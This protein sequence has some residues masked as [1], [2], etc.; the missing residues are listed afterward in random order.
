MDQGTAAVE[1]SDFFHT[2]SVQTF[3]TISVDI[4]EFYNPSQRRD[5][6][7]KW[8]SGGGGA[9]GPSAPRK[10]GAAKEDTTVAPKYNP[11]E[12]GARIRKMIEDDPVLSKRP[13]MADV[14]AWVAGQRVL[15]E[16]E[17]SVK[18]DRVLRDP[19]RWDLSVSH[20]SY[21]P[22]ISR[23]G[24]A[25]VEELKKVIAASASKFL[26]DPN[27]PANGQYE[28]MVK[29]EITNRLAQQ[30]P[31]KR[32][33]GTG[34]TVPLN[35]IVLEDGTNP[36]VR[37]SVRTREV[38]V[39]KPDISQMGEGEINGEVLDATLKV[40]RVIRKE[41]DDR[42]QPYIEDAVRVH[43][44]RRNEIRALGLDPDLIDVNKYT[45]TS[46]WSVYPKDRS[47]R[48]LTPE[49]VVSIK[50]VLNRHPSNSP[51]TT[52]EDDVRVIGAANGRQRAYL[53]VMSEIMPMGGE[54]AGTPGHR[55]GRGM[56][57]HDQAISGAARYPS[58]W[59]DLSGRAGTVDFKKTQNRA[60]YNHD[61]TS[62]NGTITLD[63]KVSTAVHE[64]GHR[65][66]ATVPGLYALEREFHTRR[67][68]GE[69]SV[70]LKKI[71]P[72]HRYG[73][74][75]MTKEDEFF[76]AYAGKTYDGSRFFEVFTMG[77]EGTS[78]GKRGASSKGSS[79][80][81]DEEHEAFILGSLVTLVRP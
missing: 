18:L 6:T 22:E 58:A 21:T 48:A 33:F 57:S 10:K 73:R 44:E 38:G 52:S 62:G 17:A 13:T 56:S 30:D 20:S 78:M 34:I 61:R 79:R 72:G 43:T 36:T 75:E 23:A 24:Y 14:D 77:I 65:F 15:A 80:P 39:R 49:E 11:T 12:F 68:A 16:A 74:D 60:H 5:R 35:D 54:V 28:E 19:A 4:E 8:T 1:Q 27:A 31:Y 64:L 9:S 67:T 76:H 70:P 40:G 63:G 26:D 81:I 53:D 59:V 66:E 51:L 50:T 55:A 25:K 29:A 7:G 71:F 46:D 69:S 32:S 42:T 45:T 37:I 41:I 2:A 3:G 47:G